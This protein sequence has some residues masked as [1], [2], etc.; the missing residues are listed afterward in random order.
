VPVSELEVTAHHEAG[1]AVAAMMRG[2]GE[3]V[4]VTIEPTADHLGFTRY[5]GHAWDRAFVIY[6]GPW[7]EARVQWPVSDINSEDDD[8]AIFD[9]YVIAALWRNA[10]GDLRDYEALCGADDDAQLRATREQVWSRETR[11]PRPRLSSWDKEY[12]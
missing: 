4:S 3:F 1:H 8:G 6:A 7:A 9:D 11:R 12:R 2:G 10:D 5:R